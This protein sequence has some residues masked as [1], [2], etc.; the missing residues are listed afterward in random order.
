MARLTDST[1]TNSTGPISRRSLLLTGLAAAATYPLMG[2]AP[3]MTENPN[4]GDRSIAKADVARAPAAPL[5]ESARSLGEFS[6][7]MLSRLVDG[8]K[9]LIFSPLSVATVVGM[10][11]NGAAENTAAEIDRTLGAGVGQVNSDLNA[12]ALYLA[13]AAGKKKSGSREGEVVINLANSVW[14]QQDFPWHA[15]F[16]KALGASYGTG[17]RLADLAGDPEGAVK[18]V[19]EW[20]AE[21]TDDEITRLLDPTTSRGGLLMVLVN[22]L[23][24]RAQWATK[25]ADPAEQPF[26][27]AGAPPV[28]VPTLRQSGRMKGH[29][30]QGWRGCMIPYVGGEMAMTIIMADPN[31]EA[32]VAKNLAGGGLPTMQRAMTDRTVTVQIPEFKVDTNV[33][34]TDLLKKLGMESAFSQ[35]ADFTSMTDDHRHINLS[36]VVHQATITVDQEGT[37]AAAATAAIAPVSAPAPSEPL[38]V[39]ADRPF[40]FF[41]TDTDGRIAPLFAGRLANPAAKND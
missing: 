30:G 36:Q 7:A 38:E 26:R 34:L 16:L 23:L 29:A 14:G 4:P 21:Q 22:A 5:A 8:E 39:I 18:K 9:N 37:S 35:M 17:I 2:C 28:N 6:G 24:F 32:A 19:N 12:A 27:I 33:A 1:V 13:G 10:I 40:W 41:I 3:P 15:D 20:V 31:A 11:R 25:F